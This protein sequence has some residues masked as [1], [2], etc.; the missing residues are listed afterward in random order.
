MDAMLERA[1]DGAARTL[2]HEKSDPELVAPTRV[3]LTGG[4]P[5][6]LGAAG[7]VVLAPRAL[8]FEETTG[9]A[10]FADVWV[11]E[12]GLAFAAEAAAHLGTVL[13]AAE[14]RV[15]SQ[16]TRWFLTRSRRADSPWRVWTPAVAARVRHHLA[17]ASEADYAAAIAA[18]APLR[19]G[20]FS[21]RLLL[22]Y[23]A[24]A[25]TAWVEEDVE[26]LDP[27]S[28]QGL[29]EFACLLTASVTTAAQLQRVADCVSIW[30]LSSDT[31]L[32]TSAAEGVGAPAAPVFARWFDTEAAD[33]ELKRRL[34]SILAALPSDE[35][36]EALL[37]RATGRYVQ[38]AMLEAAER[39]PV[40]ALRLLAGRARRPDAA[41]RVAA[42]LLRGHV[43]SHAE[44]ARSP[45]ADLDPERRATIDAVLDRQT[46]APVADPS[47]LHPVLVSP[48]WTRPRAAA[49]PRVV[50]G[51]TPPPGVRL[52]WA[53][54]ERERW[55]SQRGHLP[56]RGPVDW[57]RELAEWRAGNRRY[58][59]VALFAEA[60]PK[61]VR[62]LMADF[63]PQYLWAA[64][65]LLERLVALY[66]L[67]ALPLATYAATSKPAQHAGLLLPFE[68]TEIAL[69]MAD[70]HA[71]LKSV[72]PVALAW[73]RRHPGAAARLVPAAAG[74]PGRERR[75]AEAALRTMS[76]LLGRE[77]V[78]AAAAGHGDAARAAVEASL[79]LDPLSVVPAR[80]PALPSWIDPAVLAPVLVEDRSAALPPDAVRHVCTMLA[81]SRAGDAHPG[82]EVVRQ[83]CDRASLAEFAWSLFQRWE[84]AGAPS[85][86]GWVM[87]GLGLLGDDETVRR[88][89]PLIRTWPGEGGHARAVAGLDILAAIGSDVA[90]MHLN[91]I[92]E[93]VKFKGL[94][95]R[96]QEK[97][98]EVAAELGLTTDELAD[99]LVPD[100]GLDPDGSL[101]LDH[102][103]RRFRV[104][105]D[106]QLKP[107]VADEDGARR[108]DL[109]APG[110][111]PDAALAPEAHRRFAALKKD[112][113]TIAADQIRRLERAMV[114]QRR[115]SAPQLRSLFVDHPLVWHVAR[116]LVWGRFDV[117]GVL[118]SSFRLAEDRTLADVEDAELSLPD[119]ARVGIAHPLHLGDEVGR[120]SDL[121]ADYEILQPFPQL[122]RD[123]HRLTEAERKAATLAAFTGRR[124]DTVR[125]LGLER[126]GW[127]RGDVEDGGVSG[128]ICRPLPG[129]RTVVIELDP[130]I[131]AGS[132]TEWK[133]QT[134][135]E[136][137][138]GDRRT[139]GVLDDVA[140]SEVLRDL[141]S[142]VS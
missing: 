80:V 110:A 121:F 36:F 31:G 133:E 115:W 113:R 56:R 38:P 60:P 92:A 65:S 27:A 107:Y 137:R 90:L 136:V 77:A 88:L 76:Q 20:P 15:Y 91:G 127:E 39:F 24:P 16:D 131:I 120:W 10:A 17:A 138:L 55:L 5:T 98:G 11:A 118:S 72:R 18:L 103:R 19:A 126:S 130:G 74:R 46:A 89:A 69:A 51:L 71:R 66:E 141:R 84:A 49:R 62:P 128:W 26:T 67:D 116:R 2:D 108:K 111:R 95:A 134:L 59:E 122:G 13:L 117:R 45:A 102:G 61:L 22:S 57:E 73:F 28:G 119:D 129:D 32:L 104:G 87:D 43:A 7:L 50:E 96:A 40:R 12:R 112:V 82:V 78:L 64:Q 21:R 124:V 14:G 9:L 53:P 75:S 94:R 83:T 35:A 42:D 8:R 99:R 93:K 52:D 58:W 142:L 48:P 4:E 47:R 97:I 140:A 125:V 54:G 101:T 23:L 79:D 105:F 41:G 132:P 100:L 70:W 63:R 68:S 139:F 1:R 44:L 135:H 123:V 37:A 86:E 85:K 81:I 33:A 29:A 114:W 106:E 109:P 6:P 3:A 25:E 34:A 30:N